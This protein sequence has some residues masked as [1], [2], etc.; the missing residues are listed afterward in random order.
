MQHQIGA[1]IHTPL[2]CTGLHITVDISVCMHG[3][4]VKHCHTHP[5]FLHRYAWYGNANYDYDYFLVASGFSV[6]GMALWGG[7]AFLLKRFLGIDG[8]GITGVLNH[9]PGFKIVTGE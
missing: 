2:F 6:V 9:I 5:V 1:L 7:A 4:S 8:P 3:T